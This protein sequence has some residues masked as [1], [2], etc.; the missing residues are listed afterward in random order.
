MKLIVI[1]FHQQQLYKF[2]KN[3]LNKNGKQ[4]VYMIASNLKNKIYKSVYVEC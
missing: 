3:K 4:G 1:F 2:S